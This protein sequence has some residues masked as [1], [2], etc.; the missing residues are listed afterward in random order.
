MCRNFL[1]FLFFLFHFFSTVISG[2]VDAIKNWMKRLIHA[3]MY[4]GPRLRTP[5]NIYDRAFSA[6]GYWLLDSYKGLC[7]AYSNK[8]SFFNG[9]VHLVLKS[10]YPLED[11]NNVRVSYLLILNNIIKISSVN[12]SKVIFGF[13]Y[14]YLS[15]CKRKFIV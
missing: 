9:K 4:L 11:N 1:C 15:I 14:I 2:M 10:C 5:S 8:L 6:N 3:D 12:M 7:Q 13:V